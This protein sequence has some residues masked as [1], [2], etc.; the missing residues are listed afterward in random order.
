MNDTYG[1]AVYTGKGLP[2]E[3]LP[4][5]VL[6]ND[7]LVQAVMSADA[8]LIQAVFYPGNK[9]LQAEGITLS[10]SAPCTVQIKK[11]ADA[12]IFTATDAC[13]NPDLKEI[14]VTFNGKEVNIPL[15]QG[16]YS[17][18]QGTVTVPHNG[19]Y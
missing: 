16:M 11:E 3:N 5:H 10:A 18:K 14:T 2:S 12:Y 4:L 19:K 15:P 13:M 6:Q 7:T 8:T 9:G 17:G 1:Y